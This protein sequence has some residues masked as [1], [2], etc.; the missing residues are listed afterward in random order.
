MSFYINVFLGPFRAT[1]RKFP[2]I[3]LQIGYGSDKVLFFLYQFIAKVET[4]STSLLPSH[5]L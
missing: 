2:N 4:G 1:M 3:L 5:N